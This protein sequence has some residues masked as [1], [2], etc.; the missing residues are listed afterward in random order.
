MSPKLRCK[1]EVV[2]FLPLNSFLNNK[3]YWLIVSA[4]RYSLSRKLTL[5]GEG[6]AGNCG[7]LIDNGYKEAI[8]QGINGQ[9]RLGYG[10]LVINTSTF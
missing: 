6:W 1:L 2:E 8:C 3:G 7:P 10:C 9:R 4:N 5:V